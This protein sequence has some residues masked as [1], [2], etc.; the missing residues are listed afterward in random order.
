MTPAE[1]LEA[2]LRL[3][4]TTPRWHVDNWTKAAAWLKANN[5]IGGGQL[6]TMLRCARMDQEEH[7]FFQEKFVDLANLIDRMP[8]SYQTEGQGNQAIAHL[9]YFAGGS[10][11]WW[12]TEKDKGAADD[13]P[14]QRQSQAFGRA[15]LFG[16]GGE[17]G[18]I[19][20][21]EIIA[22]GGEMDLYWTPK[23]L[24]EIKQ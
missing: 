6:S 10:A 20:L 2:A 18:Y 23:T 4:D 7:E 3:P 22:N 16:D 9:H 5:F 14:E 15:D 19:S 21:P 8:H 1:Q 12:I 17:L 24:E 11:N 13:E